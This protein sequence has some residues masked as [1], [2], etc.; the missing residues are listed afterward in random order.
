MDLIA[1]AIVSSVDG[2]G[3]SITG[4]SNA[5]TEKW[6]YRPGQLKGKSMLTL[7]G[8]G[9][10]NRAKETILTSHMDR[11]HSATKVRFEW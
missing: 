11:K 8:S 6:G 4:L 1:A 5:I 2:I 7:T 9:T 10:V 3:D